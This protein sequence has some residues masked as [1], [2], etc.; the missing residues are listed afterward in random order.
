M[1][2]VKQYHIGIAWVL[3]ISGSIALGYFYGCYIGFI[4]FTFVAQLT[5]LWYALGVRQQELENQ[6]IAKLSRDN[7]Q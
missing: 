7:N 2:F 3:N 1:N 6:F 4:V 5:G